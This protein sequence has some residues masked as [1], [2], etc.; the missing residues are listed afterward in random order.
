MSLHRK[1]QVPKGVAG[2]VPL[3]YRKKAANLGWSHTFLLQHFS[4]P[5]KDF[6]GGAAAGSQ[7][8]SCDSAETCTP[9]GLG[10]S[11]GFGCP[12]RRV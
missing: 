1:G 5:K 9:L 8:L 10:I 2:G 7:V 4:Y 3:S 11:P 6:S 12:G